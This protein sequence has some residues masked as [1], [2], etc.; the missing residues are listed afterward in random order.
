[1][2]SNRKLHF[3]CYLQL[4][5]TLWD[6]FILTI[7]RHV[8]NAGALALSS[9]QQI[10]GYFRAAQ[11]PARQQH[12]HRAEKEGASKAILPSE[13][14]FAQERGTDSHNSLPDLNA[15]CSSECSKNSNMAAIF[16]QLKAGIQHGGILLSPRHQW[17]QERRHFPSGSATSTAVGRR[18]P[19]WTQ[20][21]A[22]SS[23]GNCREPPLPFY[24]FADSA[25]QWNFTLQ[26]VIVRDLKRV[27]S[28][29]KKHLSQLEEAWLVTR[30]RC[31]KRPSLTL[32]LGAS[33]LVSPWCHDAVPTRQLNR[34]PPAPP[35]LQPPAAFMAIHISCWDQLLHHSSAFSAGDQEQPAAKLFHSLKKEQL[36]LTVA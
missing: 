9:G 2:F 12:A 19:S 36:F 29:N 22:D 26:A 7:S 15:P 35:P 27:G 17:G 16:K 6:F 3:N 25:F 24:I 31:W 21:C 30:F 5:G 34:V 4:F 14:S 32:T 23:S 18:R 28:K 11:L 20:L 33:H 8:G 1:M 10:L 13:R